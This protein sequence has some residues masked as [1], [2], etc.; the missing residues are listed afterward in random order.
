MMFVNRH[1]GFPKRLATSRSGSNKNALDKSI[2][3]NENLSFVSSTPTKTCL[4]ASFDKSILQ[5]RDWLALEEKMLKQQCVIVGDVEN[6]MSVL[7][8]QMNV[9]RELEQ[10]KPQLDELVNTAE[11]LKA[12]SNKAQLHGKVTKLREHWDETNNKVMARKTQLD[13]MLS[14]SQRYDAKRQEVDGWLTRMEN[15]MQRMNPVGYTADVLEVQLREQKS[16]H[17][18]LHQFKQQI[19]LFN[20]LTQKLISVYQHDD[21][22]RVKKITEQVNQRYN[23]LNTSIINRGKALNSAMSSLQN[24]DKSIDNFLAWLSE[25]ESTMECVE[26]ETDRQAEK[27]STP[28]L[29]VP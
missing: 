17:A 6:I 20:Q 26:V 14:D 8:K 7:A 12:D 15:R 10:K 9:L 18:D 16:I 21:T 4:V 5:I 25:A 22:T 19:V 24:F 13:S 1:Q 29:K 3:S 27:Q 11:N 28:L 2:V 23:N